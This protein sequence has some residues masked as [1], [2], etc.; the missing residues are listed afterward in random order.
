[1]IDDFICVKKDYEWLATSAITDTLGKCSAKCFMRKDKQIIIFRFKM[2]PC[3][4]LSFS[5]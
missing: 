4:L 2:T 3:P 1:V 5:P